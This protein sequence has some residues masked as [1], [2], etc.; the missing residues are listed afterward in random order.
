MVSQLYDNGY[1]KPDGSLSDKILST[2][3]PLKPDTVID[4]ESLVNYYKQKYPK[5]WI[6]N[7]LIN[8]NVL[9]KDGFLSNTTSFKE[10]ISENDFTIFLPKLRKIN[11]NLTIDV[12]SEELAQELL[13]CIKKNLL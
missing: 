9:D 7:E 8:V 2:T 11:Y 10:K 5:T 12:L 13:R 4:I 3:L 1:L 6:Y